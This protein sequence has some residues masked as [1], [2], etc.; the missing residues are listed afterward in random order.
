[1]GTLLPSILVCSLLAVGVQAAED[2]AT[3]HIAD[4]DRMAMEDV[5]IEDY[6][7]AHKELAQALDAIKT[8]KL[9]KSAVAATTHVELGIVLGMEKKADDAVNEFKAA[10]DIDPKAALPAPYAAK[11]ELSALMDKAKA[12][13]AAT[14]VK[15]VDPNAPVTG[16]QHVPVDTAKEGDSIVIEAKVGADVKAKK[17]ELEYRPQSADDYTT[18]PMKLEKGVY[19]ATIP[20]EVTATDAVM[21]YIDARNA[22]AKIVASKGNASAPYVIAVA[23]TKKAAD[24]G[25]KQ[26]DDDDEN[27]LVDKKKKH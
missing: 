3:K 19:R 27:P 23:R 24:E 20:A 9:D 13:T 14:V 25:K 21:Y 22:K 5:E 8:A 15:P 17:V 16:I 1:M 10:L 6:A 4:L 12:A 7:S 18:V 26:D 11:A 2:K